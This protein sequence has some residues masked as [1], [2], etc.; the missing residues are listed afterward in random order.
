LNTTTTERSSFTIGW[1][2][3]TPGASKNIDGRFLDHPLVE[4]RIR[5]TLSKTY[6]ALGEH[7]AAER[8]ADRAREIYLHH[9]GPEHRDTLALAN[10]RVGALWAQGRLEETRES[11]EEARFRAEASEL[12]GLGGS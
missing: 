6:N 1:F 4:A 9:L 8:H 7:S 2:A 5:W 11:C 3:A 12:L 10:E